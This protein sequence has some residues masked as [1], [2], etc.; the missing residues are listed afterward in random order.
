MTGPGAGGP[1]PAR[2]RSGIVRRDGVDPTSR[3]DDSAGRPY[4]GAGIPPNGSGDRGP[5][6][7]PPR[8]TQAGSTAGHGSRGG[9]ATGRGGHQERTAGHR[10][11]AAGDTP[12]HR[13]PAMSRGDGTESTPSRRGDDLAADT[14]GRRVS[15][16]PGSAAGS[17]DAPDSRTVRIQ[18]VGGRREAR[19]AA[20]PRRRARRAVIVVLALLLLL[21]VVAGGGWYLYHSIYATPDYE[22][23]G[24]GDVVIQVHDGDTTS[25]IGAELARRGVVAAQASFTEAAA[26]NDRIRSVQPGYYQMR[27]RMSG[28]SAVGLLLDP[29]ARVGQL[30]IRGGV[31]LDDTRAPEGAV[32][33]G[34]L[35][36]IAQATCATIDGAKKCLTADELRTAMAKTDPA[37]LGVPDWALADVAKA[38]PT[39]RLEGLLVPG[40]Y[41]VE[42]GASAA[43]VLRG[44]LATSVDRIDATGVV[45]GAA[46]VGMSPYQVL[47]VASLIEKESTIADMPRVARVIY[48]RLG[49]GQRL[50]L[51]TTINYPLDVPSLY[52]SP[53]NRAKPGPYN[54]YLNTGL[55]VTPIAASGKDSVAAALAPADG[56]WMFF[57]PCAKDGTSCF[58]V[59]F[60]EHQANV[61]KAHANGVF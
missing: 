32:T 43:D 56:P 17:V 52:T 57:V 3:G 46:K 48:N 24:T 10:G 39:R 30:E 51:D 4:G 41:D 36:L 13:G 40:R 26:G 12:D 50:E 8:S 34:V 9:A 20:P 58:A 31:Q 7:G 16:L 53:A 28:A 47:V 14:A 35:S 2:L 18:V 27:L 55:P 21:A 60:A 49:A 23:Q 6:G 19:E 45:S 37:Q 54:T 29:G 38:P 5:A 11:R 33:P 15:D 59:T 22:G 42:P 25:Q 61:A 1:A 44:V